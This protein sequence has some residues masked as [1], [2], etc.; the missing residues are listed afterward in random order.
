MSKPNWQKE[1]DNLVNTDEKWNRMSIEGTD[2]IVGVNPKKE[3]FISIGKAYMFK[4]ETIEKLIT[5]LAS[6]K[7]E[8]ISKYLFANKKSQTPKSNGMKKLIMD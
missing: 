5:N 1:I 6:D 4:M 3:F 2:I 8:Q 7:F